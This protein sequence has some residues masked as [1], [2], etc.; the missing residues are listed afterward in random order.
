MST[1]VLEA[2]EGKY[3]RWRDETPD[4]AVGI[5]SYHFIPT[6]DGRTLVICQEGFSS[7]YFFMFSWATHFGIGDQIQSTLIALKGYVESG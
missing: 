5:R 2:V 6:G 7:W 4:G 1:V 3:I